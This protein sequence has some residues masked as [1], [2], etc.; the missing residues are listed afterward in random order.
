MQKIEKKSG[1]LGNISEV[2]LP[3][4]VHDLETSSELILR[5]SSFWNQMGVKAM[6]TL[7]KVLET[8]AASPAS[9]GLYSLNLSGFAFYDL[10]DFSQFHQS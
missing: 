9:R 3:V 4:P 1:G 7:L 6:V 8:F 10:I 5:G 2:Y